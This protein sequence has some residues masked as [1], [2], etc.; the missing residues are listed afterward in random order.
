MPDKRLRRLPPGPSVAVPAA[1]P[2]E[3]VPVLCDLKDHDDFPACA[4]PSSVD[5]SVIGVCGSHDGAPFAPFGPPCNEPHDAHLRSSELVAIKRLCAMGWILQREP[6]TR[7][8]LNLIRPRRLDH[9][10]GC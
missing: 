8:P 2:S 10:G 9:L 7:R 6:L 1:K 3:A 4:L 5:E